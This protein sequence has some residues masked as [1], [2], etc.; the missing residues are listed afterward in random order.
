MECEVAPLLGFPQTKEPGLKSEK[1]HSVGLGQGKEGS[2][3]C[4]G[5]ATKAFHSV[6]DPEGT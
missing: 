5:G 2:K 6:R 4:R 1:D 3:F